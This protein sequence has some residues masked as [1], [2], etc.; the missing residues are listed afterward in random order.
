M[1]PNVAK[2]DLS[3]SVE[4]NSNLI[5]SGPI[6]V[7]HG[8]NLTLSCIDRHAFPPPSFQ[9]FS[10]GT[11]ISNTDLSTSVETIG[12]NQSQLA[13]YN[14]QGGNFTLK[15]TA[16]NS[17]GTG[18]RTITVS[19]LSKCIALICTLTPISCYSLIITVCE[20]VFFSS[21]APP[22]LT[23]ITPQVTSGLVGNNLTLLLVFNGGHTPLTA[24]WSTNG[25]TE[26]V[27]EGGRVILDGQHSIN[28]TITDLILDDEGIYK[29]NVTNEIGSSVFRYTVHV[30]GEC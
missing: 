3:L 24:Q 5:T 22:S 28:L 1:I 23:S 19:V 25:S 9:W 13:L 7:L 10:N 8:A 17:V 15:C 27:V 12:N 14:V 4:Y 21:S 20:F 11:E 29:L 2:P 6:E 18:S 26:N 30:Y 16:T